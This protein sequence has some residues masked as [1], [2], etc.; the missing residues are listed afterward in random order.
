MSMMMMMMMII[1]LTLIIGTLFV[2]WRKAL[3]IHLLRHELETWNTI[4]TLQN[5]TK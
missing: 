2:T 3:K 5:P 1:K 4:V